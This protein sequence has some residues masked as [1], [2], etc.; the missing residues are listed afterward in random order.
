MNVEIE[1]GHCGNPFT[2]HSTLKDKRKHCSRACKVAAGRKKHWRVCAQCG[3]AFYKEISPSH[4]RRGKGKY[5]SPECAGKARQNRI[6]VSCIEC[7]KNFERGAYQEGRAKYCSQKCLNKARLN[8]I[9]NTCPTCGEEFETWASQKRRH[10]S[11]GCASNGSINGQGYRLISV[12]GS[13]VLE[14]RHIMEQ[15]LKRSLLTHEN[16]HHLNGQRTDNRL[17]NLELWSKSQPPG[18]RVD[19]KIAWAVEFLRQYGYGVIKLEE[20]SQSAED[21]RNLLL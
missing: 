12:N 21:T 1:C 10:C 2:V 11:R 20:L 7:G 18:Q 13:R 4:E 3:V 15:H 19:D 8:R 6:S 5:C 16:V 14:H 17:D 9:Q